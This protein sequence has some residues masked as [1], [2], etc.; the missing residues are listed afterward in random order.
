LATYVNPRD[1]EDIRSGIRR[2][3]AQSRDAR[4]S[5]HVLS[6]FT[7]DHTARQL[8]EAYNAAL[9]QNAASRGPL[10]V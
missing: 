4:L 9:T 6:N 2:A 3:L 7:W 1:D 10:L 5:R 8:V